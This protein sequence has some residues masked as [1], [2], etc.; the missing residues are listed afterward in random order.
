LGKSQSIF[1]AIASRVRW[2][3]WVLRLQQS[4]RGETTSERIRVT[5]ERDDFQWRLVFSVNRNSFF[6]LADADSRALMVR[7][8]GDELALADFLNEYPLHFY[9]ADLSRL[10]GEEWF[11]CKVQI[12]PFDRN[13][14]QIIQWKDDRVAIDKEAYEVCGQVVKSFNLIDN[15]KDLIRHIR[16][17]AKSGSRF[18]KDDV[19]AF[20][21]IVR[22]RGPRPLEYQFVVVQPGISKEGLGED[23]AAILAADEYVR[24]IGARDLV[25]LASE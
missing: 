3:L 6:Q 24:N 10:R 21:N 13:L 14:I 22:N 17:R 18:V 12:E 15:E 8:G 25:A 16:R 23:S 1:G 19:D 9:F 4:D 7:Y 11:P 20:E 5:L 2:P